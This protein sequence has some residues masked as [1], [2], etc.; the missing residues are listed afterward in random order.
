MISG[1]AILSDDNLSGDPSDLSVTLE[2]VVFPHF[3]A[4]PFCISGAMAQLQFSVLTS[5]MPLVL[6]S[7]Q[8]TC[9]LSPVY[10]RFSQSLAYV[11]SL[12]YKNHYLMTFYV[13]CFSSF[14]T[15]TW[16]LHLYELLAR[17]REA[18]VTNKEKAL[19]TGLLFPQSKSL[20]WWVTV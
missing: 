9:L 6:Q 1:G 3:S 5:A 13:Q 2:W 7:S 4:A 18:H 16:D 15:L 19:P 12:L 20:H 10:S 14:K 11:E 8:N 17:T